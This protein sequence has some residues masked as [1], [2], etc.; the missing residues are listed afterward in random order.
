[1]CTGSRD[2][3]YCSLHSEYVVYI[4]VRAFSMETEHNILYAKGE[5]T[6]CVDGQ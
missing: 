6:H 2:A 4:G 5:E 1:M 3:T